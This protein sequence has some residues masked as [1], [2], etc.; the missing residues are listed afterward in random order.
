MIVES[1]FKHI[2]HGVEGEDQQFRQSRF[3]VHLHQS[4]KLTQ[5][6]KRVTAG[7]SDTNY[8]IRPKDDTFIT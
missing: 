4:E 8:R 1:K 5:K 7:T 3:P 6:K 2:K